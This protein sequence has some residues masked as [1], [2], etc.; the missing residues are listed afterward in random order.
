[1]RVGVSLVVVAGRRGGGVRLMR[2]VM[3]EL[4]L[5]VF[6]LLVP[7]LAARSLLHLRHGRS[8]FLA[9]VLGALPAS[10]PVVRLSAAGAERVARGRPGQ[11][12]KAVTG[13]EQR[14]LGRK[15]SQVEVIW[16]ERR[17]IKTDR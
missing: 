8:P 11:R 13:G 16:E 9:H 10:S 2:M 6:A 14:G 5:F 4:M 3:V 7:L 12:R 17:R 1:M 15:A